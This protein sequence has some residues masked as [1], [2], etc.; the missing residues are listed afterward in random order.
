MERAGGTEAVACHRVDHDEIAVRRVPCVVGV[1]DAGRAFLYEPGDIRTLSEILI[2]LIRDR[3]MRLETGIRMRERILNHFSIT[4][5]KDKYVL[6]Y[7][8]LVEEKRD[9]IWNCS[10]YPPD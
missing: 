5:I 6:A 7:R 3:K 4:K 2:Q 1:G 10:E 9:E 8:M